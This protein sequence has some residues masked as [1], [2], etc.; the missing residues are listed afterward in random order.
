MDAKQLLS[1]FLQ[2]D[3]ILNTDSHPTQQVSHPP[4]SPDSG[5]VAVKTECPT[6]GKMRVPVLK[7]LAGRFVIQCGV[8]HEWRVVPTEPNMREERV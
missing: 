8:C 4:D 6:C 5:E 3:E 1:K 2:D 7:T